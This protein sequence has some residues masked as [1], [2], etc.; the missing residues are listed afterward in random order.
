MSFS[1]EFVP[2]VP[3]PLRELGR[4][5]AVDLADETKN[6]KI[7]WILASLALMTLQMSVYLGSGMKQ[8][9]GKKKHSKKL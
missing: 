7:T 9:D 3:T 8:K 5:R 2:S 4:R 1:C 6:P